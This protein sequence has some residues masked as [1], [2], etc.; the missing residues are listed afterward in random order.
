MSTL[1]CS[2]QH[3][4]LSEEKVLITPLARISFSQEGTDTPD[5]NSAVV[6]APYDNRC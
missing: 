6:P 5:F 2:F 3:K 1:L 4:P